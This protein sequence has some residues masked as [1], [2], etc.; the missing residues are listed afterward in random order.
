MHIGDVAIAGIAITNDGNADGFEDGAPLVEHLAV[1][2]EPGIGAGKAGRGD[3]KTAHEGQGEA[4][5]L[6]EPG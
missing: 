5:Q 4:S 3:G 2:K 1:G 6:D